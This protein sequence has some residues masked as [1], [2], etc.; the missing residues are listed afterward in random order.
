[1]VLLDMNLG[2]LEDAII[3]E[4]DQNEGIKPIRITPQNRVYADLSISR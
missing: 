3:P 2:P 1:M 4:E